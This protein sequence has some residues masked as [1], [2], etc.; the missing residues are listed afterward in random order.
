MWDYYELDHV[1]VSTSSESKQDAT[2]TG[3]LLRTQPKQF[4]PTYHTNG[5]PNECLSKGLSYKAVDDWLIAAVA[6]SA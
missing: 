2:T 6:A 1:H 4:P 3:L 5:C